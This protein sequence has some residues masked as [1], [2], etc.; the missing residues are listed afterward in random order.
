MSK[1]WNSSSVKTIV[2]LRLR[3]I[4]LVLS[5]VSSPALATA[6]AA[7][8]EPVDLVL[9][10]ACDASGSVEPRE[11]KL[12]LDG[13]AA[14]FRN[15]E[16]LAAIKRG[17]RSRIAVVLLS[18]ADAGRPKDV[19]AWFVIDSRETAEA[20][21]RMVEHFPRR[22]EGGTG[23]GSAIAEAVRM[24]Q[25]SAFAPA[26]KIIDVSGDGSETPPRLPAVR[27]PQAISMADAFGMTING[28]AIVNEE[29]DIEQYYREHVVTGPDHFV[30][31]ADSY[32]SFSHAYLV[33]LLRELA[34][35]TSQRDDG[36]RRCESDGTD[37]RSC[38]AG[39]LYAVKSDAREG[40]EQARA[41]GSLSSRASPM[42]S[43]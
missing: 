34:E 15:P 27:L 41:G 25:Q 10:Q 38:D 19:S 4:I 5:L 37:R 35:K 29:P 7:E 18:W 24:I 20:F 36:E 2:M 33:K 43:P 13:I 14:A 17:P 42:P 1:R 39:K 11:W 12:E 31:L 22:P 32:E 21:A 40:Q 23:I 3:V 8:G 6:I 9:V 30:V 28:L 26:R 16:V